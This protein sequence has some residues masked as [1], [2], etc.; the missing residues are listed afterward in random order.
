MCKNKVNSVVVY[1][2]DLDSVEI[3]DMFRDKLGDVDESTEK[4]PILV[5]IKN[6][7]N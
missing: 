5:K 4:L 6:K 1:T 3:I 2:G 7:E